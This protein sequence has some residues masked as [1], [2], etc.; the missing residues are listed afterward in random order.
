M[1]D[2]LKID[3]FVV[4]LYPVL[5]DQTDVFSLF[6]A[7]LNGHCNTIGGVIVVDTGIKSIKF[8]SQ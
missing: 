4:D 2:I 8:L 1:L 3:I 5:Q 7:G 6:H